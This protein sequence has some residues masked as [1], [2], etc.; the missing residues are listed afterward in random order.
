MGR[1]THILSVDQGTTSSR[2]IIFDQ[3]G[4]IRGVGQREYEQFFPEEG[5]VEQDAETIWKDTL[6]MCRKAMEEAGVGTS[7]VAGV[8]ITNQRETIVVWDRE[9]GVPIH[10]AVV[11][12]DRRTAKTCRSLSDAGHEAMIHAK[13]GLLINPYFSATKLQW[14]LDHVPGARTAAEAG[15]LAAGTIDCFLLWRF[16]KGR[17]HATDATNAGRTLLFNIATQSWDD[18]LLALFNIPRGL[19]PEVKDTV[20]DYGACD[21]EWFGEALPIYALVGDQHSATVGQACF[22]PGMWKATYGTGCFV[23]MN[24]GEAK[25]TSHNKLLATMGYRV[26]GK[27]TYALEG[28]IFIAG[29]AIQWLRDKLGLIAHAKETESIARSLEGTGGVYVVPAFAGLGAPYWDAD[30]RGAVLGMTLDTR[31]EHIIRATLESVAYQTCD[32]MEAFKGDIAASGMDIMPST[33]RVDGGMVANDWFCQFL[34]DQLGVPVERPQV[35]ET[36][37]LGAAYLAGIGAGLYDGLHAVSEAWQCE[38]R[39]EPS[40]DVA[41]RESRYAGWQEAVARV[42]SQ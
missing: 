16:T 33:L 4:A 20:D 30:A 40:I 42:R 1:K 15:K 8:G 24:T 29:A 9:T 26:N 2:A 32:L 25:L 18:E 28:S 7:A 12:Q 39:F 35:I 31:K 21:A 22:E 27:S 14:I 5:W 36:T 41:K 19:L 10:R 6:A 3:K 11:W 37:A 13:T 23:V 17:V 34:A 38:K